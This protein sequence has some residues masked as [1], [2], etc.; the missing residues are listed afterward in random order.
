MVTR[1][2]YTKFHLPGFNLPLN[3]TPSPASKNSVRGRNG[4]MRVQESPPCGSGN[5][6]FPNALH[7][8]ER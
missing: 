3:F 1:A 5:D 2:E 7:S 6:L 8:W 4:K